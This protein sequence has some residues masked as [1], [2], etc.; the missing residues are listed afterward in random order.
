MVIN[1]QTKIKLLAIRVVES[2]YEDGSKKP[3]AGKFLYKQSPNLMMTTDLL[4]NLKLVYSNYFNTPLHFVH[5]DFEII[6]N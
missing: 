6:E 2:I 5:C 4:N 3:K 1:N